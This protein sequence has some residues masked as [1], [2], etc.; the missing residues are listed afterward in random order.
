MK[1]D[2]EVFLQS[3][4]QHKPARRKTDYGIKIYNSMKNAIEN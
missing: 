1:F 3:I 2:L 4:G